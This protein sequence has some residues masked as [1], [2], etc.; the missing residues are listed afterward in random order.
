MV[1]GSNPE[2]ANQI[3]GHVGSIRII[4]RPL[5]SQ[6]FALESFEVKR[7]II[8]RW[9]DLRC[10][11]QLQMLNLEFQLK[12]STDDAETASVKWPAFHF[13][14][15][16]NNIIRNILHSIRRYLAD[17]ATSR[18]VNNVTAHLTIRKQPNGD[19]LVF[20]W[21]SEPRLKPEVKESV[22]RGLPTPN[23]AGAWGWGFVLVGAILH[24]TG[25]SFN[26][27]KP[28][29]GTGTLITLSIPAVW[30][31]NSFRVPDEAIA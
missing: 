6:D 5:S 4:R 28:R 7:E 12:M 20:L 31:P 17:S 11:E 19:V 9:N 25:G 14:E 2:L 16:I 13:T 15:V 1:R 23:D 24:E 30:K 27:D 26:L 18:Q 8:Q 3:T 21:N 29:E 10:N 22:E